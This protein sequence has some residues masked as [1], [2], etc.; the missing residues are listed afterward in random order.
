MIYTVRKL[1]TEAYY[2]SSIVAKDLEQVTGDQLADGLL[3]FNEVISFLGADIKRIP[4]FKEYNFLSVPEVDKYFIPY[5]VEADTVTYLNQNV[6]F[7]TYKQTRKEFFGTYRAENINSLMFNC[8]LERC[9][10]GSNLYFY[11]KPANE[12]PCKIWGKF[13]LE[14]V[15]ED[16]IDLDLL[17]IYDMYFITYLRYS[18]AEYICQEYNID[19]QNEAEER[20]REIEK[21]IM[22]ISPPDLTIDKGTLF[23]CGGGSLS[24]ADINIG[25]GW[26]PVD[27]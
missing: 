15:S 16:Q 20:L 18:L 5:L 2:L 1:I 14:M 25:K 27:Y 12:Y 9:L 22:D 11:F 23:P 21:K 10:G 19:F 8:H 7:V 3:K 24:Y 6:R 4:Y 26:R 17:T 13:G